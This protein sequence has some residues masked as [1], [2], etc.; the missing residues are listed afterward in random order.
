MDAEK[1]TRYLCLDRRKHDLEVELKQTAHD[2]KDLERAVVDEL[3]NS[4]MT[5]AEAEGRRLVLAPKVEA[6]PIEGRR[7]VVEALKEAGL[8]QYIPQDYNDSKL[9]AYVREIADEVLSRAE[10]EQRVASAEEI[11]AALPAPL[12]RA[13]NVW[14]GHQLRNRKA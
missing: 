13:L 3:L 14:L 2:L 12:G 1:V 4:G 11:R 9:R 7:A 10:D 8:D 5:G 6:S